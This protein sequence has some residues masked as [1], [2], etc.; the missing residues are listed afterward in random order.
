MECGIA[1][2][3]YLTLLCKKYQE[4]L[5]D[6]H[7]ASELPG[8]V[9]SLADNNAAQGN[10]CKKITNVLHQYFKNN[11]VHSE[12]VLKALRNPGNTVVSLK[13]KSTVSEE[14][15]F[16]IGEAGIKLLQ[17]TENHCVS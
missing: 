17:R 11:F 10:H 16:G 2:P 12:I 7:R 1:L 9:E 14:N 13:K 8:G 15:R 3:E 4:I 6:T 5:Q